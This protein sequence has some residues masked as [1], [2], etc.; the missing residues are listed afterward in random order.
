ML[1]IKYSVILSLS[2]FQAIVMCAWRCVTDMR[3]TAGRDAPSEGQTGCLWG[4]F[5]TRTV[6]YTYR[7]VV[8]LSLFSLSLSLFLLISFWLCFSVCL[9]YLVCESCALSGGNAGDQ[10]TTKRGK[11]HEIYICH[12]AVVCPLF[13][14]SLQY[15]EDENIYIFFFNLWNGK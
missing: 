12:P 6:S 5:R 2:C 15:Y 3:A 4:P 7:A 13:K 14:T 9:L 8:F 10:L 1:F 11:D